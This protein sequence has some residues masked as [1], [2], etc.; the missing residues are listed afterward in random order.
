MH[1]R[2]LEARILAHYSLAAGRQRVHGKEAMMSSIRYICLSDLHL[3][4]D[5]SILT[6]FPADDRETDPVGSPVL[7]QLVRCLRSLVPDDT[8]PELKPVTS[9]TSPWPRTTRHSWYSA[10][11]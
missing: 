6:R 2:P 1:H 8:E 9:S 4:E 3:G 7:D 5:N 11:S 10:R